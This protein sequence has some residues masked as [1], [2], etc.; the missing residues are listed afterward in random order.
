METYTNRNRIKVKRAGE[1]LPPQALVKA[2]AVRAFQKRNTVVPATVIRVR[3]APPSPEPTG[4]HEVEGNDA[5][6]SSDGVAD[7]IELET[8]KQESEESSEESTE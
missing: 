7:S 2:Q 3:S 1:T 5:N 6:A 8:N 4:D